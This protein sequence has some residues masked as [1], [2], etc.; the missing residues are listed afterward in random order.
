M[1]DN[2][3]IKSLNITKP[4]ECTLAHPELCKGNKCVIG[5]AMVWEIST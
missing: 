4:P 5:D 3:D 2:F 1:F